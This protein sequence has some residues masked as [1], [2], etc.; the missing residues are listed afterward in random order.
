M[1]SK[2]TTAHQGDNLQSIASRQ[3]MFCVPL[4]GNQLQIDLDGDLL[5]V[6]LQVAQQ[7]GDGRRTIEFARLPFTVMV[8]ISCRQVAWESEDGRRGE[9]R[10]LANHG[11]GS[12][13]DV[14]QGERPGLRPPRVGHVASPGQAVGGKVTGRRIEHVDDRKSG[15]RGTGAAR[16]TAPGP[17]S[18]GK[19]AVSPGPIPGL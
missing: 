14:L 2:I 16:K 12:L 3:L 11:G 17:S 19:T 1:V 15:P 8:M 5:W 7:V 10:P 18:S 6:E 4:S 13:T 9:T